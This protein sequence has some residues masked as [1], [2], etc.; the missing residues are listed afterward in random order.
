MSTPDIIP[1]PNSLPKPVVESDPVVAAEVSE[2]LFTQ[3]EVNAF[4]QERVGREQAT[5]RK[6]IK[7]IEETAGLSEREAL[8]HRLDAATTAAAD[9]ASALSALET[10]YEVRLAAISAGVPVGQVKAITALADLTDIRDADGALDRAAVDAA[11]TAVL[12]EYPTLIALQTPATSPVAEPAVLAD[13]IGTGPANVESGHKTPT[14]TFDAIAA[15][16]G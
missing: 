9:S 7:V 5:H 14:S 4:I 11:V 6:A 15:L 13:P 3:N 8:Q 2:R 16:Y 10:S 12:S 1:T